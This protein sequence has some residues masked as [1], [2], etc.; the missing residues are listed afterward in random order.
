M[1]NNKEIWKNIAGFEGYQVSNFGRVKSFYGKKERILKAGLRS[2]GYLNVILCK[3]GKMKCFLIHRLVA[4]AFIDNP[5]NLPVINH[6]DENKQ[7]NQVSNLEWCTY[8][9]NNSYN[10]KGKKTGA[11]LAKKVGQ[12]SKDGKL[13][14]IWPSMIEADRNDF[15]MGNICSCCQGKRKTHGGFIWQYIEN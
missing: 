7:N 2:N 1:E 13:I 3:N 10:D 12:Y 14:K 8:S 11:K 5:D 4:N 9:Y 15:N 6:I